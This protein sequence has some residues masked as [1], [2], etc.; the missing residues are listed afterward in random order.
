MSERN[1][2]AARLGVAAAAALLGAGLFVVALPRLV[3]ESLMLPGNAVLSAVESGHAVGADD[4]QRLIVSR[5]RGLLWSESGRARVELAS[6]Q[7][8]LAEREVGGG[9]RYHVLMQQA[10]QDL[11]DGLAR[12]P[13]NPYAWTWLAYAGLAEGEPARRIVPML[14]MAIET[15]PVQPNLTFSRLRLC[16]IEWPYFAPA[17]VAVLREQVALAWREDADELVRLA[18]STGR[19]DIVRAALGESHRSAFDRRWQ[20]GD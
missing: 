10:M 20:E 3:A 8:R 19:Q 18:R 4:L 5:Q 1:G 6:A 17:T 12:A 9:A 15:A 11:R 7:I 2:I 16:L 13:A 14:T